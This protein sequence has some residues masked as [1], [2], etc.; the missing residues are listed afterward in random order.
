MFLDWSN[1]RIF[2][3]TGNT[4]LRKSWHGLSGIIAEQIQ[5]DPYSGHVYLF[6]NRRRNILKVIYWQKNGFCIWQKKI[7]KQR[8]P[9]LYDDSEFKEL[10]S[11]N[12]QKLL[13]GNDIFSQHNEIFPEWH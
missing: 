9:W 10:D 13:N 8:F 6:A 7:S 1:T 5:H 3:I 11:L 12:L 4:D 2:L